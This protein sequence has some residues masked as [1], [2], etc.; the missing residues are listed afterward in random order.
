V[1][2]HS[3]LRSR[4]GTSSTACLIGM[5]DR[6]VDWEA[7]GRYLTGE[8]SAAEAEAMRR[9]LDARPDHAELVAALDQSIGRLAHATPPDLDVEAAL[10][11]VRARR[12]DPQLHVPPSRQAPARRPLT[13]QP[14]RWSTPWLR[15]A[16]VVA[17]L[18]GS[19]LL[20]RSTKGH[21]GRATLP[22]VAQ[23]F[24]TAVGQRDSLRLPDGTRVV[25][26]PGSRLAVD[27]GYGS[28][29]R[30]VGLRGEAYFE[31][32]H[33]SSHPFVV[34]AGIARVRDIGT[35]FGV[36]TDPGDGVSVVVTSGA[37]RVHVGEGI[38]ADSGVLLRQGDRGVLSPDGRVVAQR[39]AATEDDLAWTR[40]RLIFRDA[41][42]SQVSADLRRWYGVELRVADSSLAGK[43]VNTTF[44]GEPADRVVDVIAL[45]L[46][47]NVEHRGDT[48]VLHAPFKN[49]RRR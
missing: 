27:Q 34:R 29:H 33:G 32:Q 38:P 19:A 49:A 9:W 40:G 30:E 48:A 2:P 6:P 39:G 42:L 4:K 22:A 5:S 26:G 21:D 45:I 17:A 16:A 13:P 31:V 8:S 35:A 3:A 43:H 25:L 41:T 28:T 46:G 1:R 47:A 12:D 18:A 11:Q 10:R 36:H 14:N 37:V 24:E 44:E 15:A 20:W 7:L 23:T